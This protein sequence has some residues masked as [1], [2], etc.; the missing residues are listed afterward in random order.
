MQDFSTV[1]DLTA[2]TADVDVDGVGSFDGGGGVG[3]GVVAEILDPRPKVRLPCP[4]LPPFCGRWSVVGRSS[5]LS[6]S[7]S[8]FPMFLF[9]SIIILERVK[10][11]N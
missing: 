3:G 11:R 8:L 1:G 6:F 5:S 9:S 7:L 10:H 4:P 2:H